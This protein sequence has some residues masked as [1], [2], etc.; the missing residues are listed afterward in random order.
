MSG[1][2]LY[3]VRAKNNHRSKTKHFTPLV[4]GRTFEFEAVPYR[5][6]EAIVSKVALEDFEGPKAQKL[7]KDEQWLKEKVLSHEQVVEEVMGRTPP[8]IPFKFGTVFRNREGLTRMLKAHHPRF[9]KLLTHL[10]GKQ[11]WGVKLF[12]NPNILAQATRRADQKLAHLAAMMKGKPSGKQYF[13]EKEL[14][15][16]L[17][18]KVEE[19]QQ[20]QAD[21]L[22]RQLSLFYEQCV[23]TPVL[24]KTL[25]GR[26]EEMIV[27]AALMVREEGVAGVRQC[28]AEWNRLHCQEGFSAELTGPWPPYNF[29]H[30]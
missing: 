27:N 26:D 25:T 10:R 6:V 2:Y 20:A 8:V 12:S 21:D 4:A 16:Q 5:D 28:V 30:L 7:L 18:E 22:V 1:F 3:C 13:L 14:E 29:A 24:P 23:N 17:K 19:S 11:E 15:M 9:Q